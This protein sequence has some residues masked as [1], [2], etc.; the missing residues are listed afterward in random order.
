MDKNRIREIL[1]NFSKKT[2]MVIGDIIMDQ[3]IWGKVSRIS[4]EAPVPV[5]D[6]M[7]ESYLLG[8]AA[9][10]LNN[11]VSLGG[12][13]LIC[14]VIGHDDIGRKII[15]KLRVRG[16][17]TGGIIVTSDRPTTIKTRI[18][19]HSQQVVR[20]DR[21]KREDINHNSKEI[22]KE[23]LKNRI[24]EID[25]MIISD[26][27]KGVITKG[28]VNEII[29]LVNSKKLPV[30]ADPKVGHFDLYEGLTLITPNIAE[31]STG[32]G[33]PIVDNKSL[34][35][36]GRALI[37][38]LRSKAVLITRG[39]EGMTLIEDNGEITYIPAVA[40]K[41]FDVTGAGDTVIGVMTLAIAA[42]ATMKE[43][44]VIANHAAGIVVGKVGTAIVEMG[45]LKG[46]FQ[47]E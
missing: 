33:I 28:L 30:L 7:E 23:Y 8:G 9:N 3:Y 6:V 22:I 37:E 34:E 13:A 10:V 44:A 45:E 29:S 4:P 17:D 31:A 25:G 15:H 1:N 36:A 19:A 2:I 14:G 43:A 42:G 39:E 32:A 5:V 41:V 18:V 38:K 16:I 26:Y 40:K 47:I 11:I 21:E 24:S 27:Y 46:S 12:N 35:D 20:Y